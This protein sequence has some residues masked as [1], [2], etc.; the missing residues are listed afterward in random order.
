MSIFGVIHDGSN[1]SAYCSIGK[2]NMPRILRPSVRVGAIRPINSGGQSNSTKK[3][4]ILLATDK[5]FRADIFRPC[6]AFT[7]K[8]HL[9]FY[10]QQMR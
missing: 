6:H 7:G 3:A 2:L 5:W 9:G 4:Q 8:A 1:A 10:R